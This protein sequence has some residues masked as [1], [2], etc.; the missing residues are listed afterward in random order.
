MHD[1]DAI[2]ELVSELRKYSQLCLR[3]LNEEPAKELLGKAAE[4][5]EILSRMVKEAENK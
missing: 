2:I 1:D 4:T 5:I 3:Y